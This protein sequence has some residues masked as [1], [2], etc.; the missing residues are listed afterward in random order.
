VGAVSGLQ[1]GMLSRD[2]PIADTEAG[3]ATPPIDGGARR[4]VSGLE[5]RKAILEC[6]VKLAGRE[7]IESVSLNRLADYAGLHK[8]TI[9]RAFGSRE[10]LMAAYAQQLCEHE[11]SRWDAAA[12]DARQVS[13]PDRRR[14]VVDAMA[15][16]VTERLH[17][18]PIRAVAPQSLGADH[19]VRVALVE[20]ECAFRALLLELATSV[21]VAEPDALADTLMLIGGGLALAPLVGLDAQDVDGR[22]R[23]LSRRIILGY[24]ESDTRR[25][26]LVQK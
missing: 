8:M 18:S 6:L 4:R 26:D 23:D 17:A 9:Y 3:F 1:P 16:L 22:V 12:I 2:E 14:R 10:A 24:L 7:G 15:A 19:P 20:H 25:L 13:A 5:A 11:R 21:G